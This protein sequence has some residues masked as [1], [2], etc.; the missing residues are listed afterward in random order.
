LDSIAERVA[1]VGP[2]P[3]GLAAERAARELLASKDL[4]CQEPKNLAPFD[5][6]KLKVAK[7]RARPRS[8]AN[9]LPPLPADMIRNPALYIEKDEEDMEL[10]SW[11]GSRRWRS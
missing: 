11:S 6:T 10:Q 8:V 9:F 2:P 4:Y 7:G 5:L 1:A 3:P